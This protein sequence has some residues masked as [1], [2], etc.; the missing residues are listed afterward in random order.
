[1]GNYIV[2]KDWLVVVALLSVGI[3]LFMPLT[4]R[5]DWIGWIAVALTLMM[6]IPVLLFACFCIYVQM[7]NVVSSRRSSEEDDSSR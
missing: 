4:Q 1:M 5:D 2:P 6:A 7:R 3:G